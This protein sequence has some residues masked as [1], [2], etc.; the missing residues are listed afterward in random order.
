MKK[1]MGKGEEFKRGGRKMR[2]RRRRKREW[3]E[4]KMGLEE[5]GAK[6]KEAI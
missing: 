2:G 5:Q 4:I 3:R 6:K 1:D